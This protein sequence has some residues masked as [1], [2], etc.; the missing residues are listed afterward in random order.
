MNGNRYEGKLRK[1]TIIISDKNN[2]NEKIVEL[3]DKT[4]LILLS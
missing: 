1:H 4:T 3:I 2:E